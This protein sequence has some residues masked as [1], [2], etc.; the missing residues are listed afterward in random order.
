VN[1]LGG[2]GEQSKKVLSYISSFGARSEVKHMLAGEVQRETR[3]VNGAKVTALTAS[4]T[5]VRGPHVPRLRLD[6]I[7]EMDLMVLDAALGQTMRQKGIETNIVMSSTHQYMDGP[8]TEMLKRADEREWPVYEW[9]WKETSAAPTGWLMD[10]EIARK[11]RE[12]TDYMWNV[13]YD[14]QEPTPGARALMAESVEAMFKRELGEFDGRPS[15]Y[16]EIEEPVPGAMYST[17]ADWARKGHFTTIITTRTDVWPMKVVAFERRNREPWPVIIGRLDTRMERFPG[18]AAHDATGIGDVIAGFMLND[19]KGNIMAG[20]N[21]TQMILRYISA[22]ENGQ[23]EAPYIRSMYAEHKNATG[24]DVWGTG[25]L[26][27]SLSA[28][29]NMHSTVAAVAETEDY[30]F[31]G[32]RG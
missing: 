9:C 27:D 5:S 2:S 11:R 26:P 16:I 19:A 25:H 15:E 14:L 23:Y 22:V 21:R 10:E 7:D 4:Q 18:P 30:E 29:S 32:Y 13:E 20:K 6:E 17:G 12:I 8:M 24:E 28:M 31:A 3:F 1:V